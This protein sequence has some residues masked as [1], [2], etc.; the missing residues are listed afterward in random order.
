MNQFLLSTSNKEQ[1]EKLILLN[2]IG[3]VN[4]IEEDLITIEEAEKIIFSPYT[5]DLFNTKELSK[6]LI[7]IVH[8]G[9]ELEDIDSLIPEKLSESLVQIKNL[10][11]ELLQKRKN[12]KIENKVIK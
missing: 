3:L 7:D 6:E 2:I 5:M 1:L 8:L 10:S 11:I 4:C 9:T 12:Y